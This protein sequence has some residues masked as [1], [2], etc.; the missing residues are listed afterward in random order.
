MLKVGNTL[1]PG[2]TLLLSTKCRTKIKGKLKLYFSLIPMCEAVMKIL[3]QIPNHLK[4]VD[5]ET[6]FEIGSKESYESSFETWEGGRDRF[7]R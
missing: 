4:G 2:G 1:L 5:E 6:W 3:F 7:Y